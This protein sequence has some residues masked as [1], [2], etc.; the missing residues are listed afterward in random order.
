MKLITETFINNIELIDKS[1]YAEGRTR[2]W[3]DLQRFMSQQLFANIQFDK[4]LET[5]GAYFQRQRFQFDRIYMPVLPD[6]VSRRKVDHFRE[7]LRKRKL[8]ELLLRI[9]PVELSEDAIRTGD[10]Q[11]ILQCLEECA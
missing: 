9:C 4:K 6:D 5:A 10:P 2:F 7:I 8:G 11:R 3:H 1:E